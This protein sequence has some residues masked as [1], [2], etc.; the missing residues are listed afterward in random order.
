MLASPSK[1]TTKY[2]A[3]DV[4]EMRCDSGTATG[5]RC[6]NVAT[7]HVDYMPEHLR[8]S[9]RAAGNSGSYPA[10]GSERLHVCADCAEMLA[11][12]SPAES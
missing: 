5:E 10:N 7:T 2:G 4:S 8:E 6:E 3:R 9:H 11:E 1:A 12:T